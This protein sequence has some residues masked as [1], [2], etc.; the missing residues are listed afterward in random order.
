[1]TKVPRSR[2]PAALGAALILFSPAGRALAQCAMCRDAVNAAAPGV[3]E[4]MNYAI[5]GL[6]FAPYVIAVAAALTISPKL[7]ASLRGKL[8]RLVS[9]GRG[10]RS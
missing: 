8:E 2:I 3:Q 10:A 1:M 5:V 9:Q 7:R 4:A 6:A